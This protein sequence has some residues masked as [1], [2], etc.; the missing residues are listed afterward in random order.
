MDFS[1]FV[2]SAAALGQSFTAF[3][4]IGA[5]HAAEDIT[6]LFP[7]LQ[8]IGIAAEHHMFQA[9]HGVNT[10]KGMI[11][12]LGLLTGAAG[13]AA[14]NRQNL[15]AVHLTQ[16]VAA[17]CHGLCQKGYSQLASKQAQ[18]TALTKG[19][20]MYLRYHVTGV[21]GEAERGFP[22]VLHIAL[23]VYRARSASGMT[24]NDALCDT[25]LALMAATTD[26]NILG[27]HDMAALA[28]AQSAARQALDAGGMATSTGRRAIAALDEDLTQ[29]WISPG[30]S[31][32]LIALTYFLYDLERSAIKPGPSARRNT[33]S[34]KGSVLKC[35]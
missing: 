17:M 32:D 25:L 10:H 18:G 1:T 22:A 16:L 31:A 9:T 34:I 3:A 35:C 30:G 2:A 15:Q 23:P 24:E 13:W 4:R 14:A 11:F 19:E 12:S 26:T 7:R 29:R 27:R 8:A 28:Y 6:R 5:E 20:A 21:R 33:K